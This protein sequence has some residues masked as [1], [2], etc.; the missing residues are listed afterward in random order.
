MHT[1]EGLYVLRHDDRVTGL[2]FSPD[3]SLLAAVD[4]GS[5]SFHLIIARIE[6]GL[7]LSLPDEAILAPTPRDLL[8][9]LRPSAPSARPRSSDRPATNPGCIP[10]PYRVSDR[11]TRA[12][13]LGER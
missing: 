12:G 11:P 1:G 8:A 5:N 10:V 7:D 3:G 4:L 6:H 13:T 9:L 2:A